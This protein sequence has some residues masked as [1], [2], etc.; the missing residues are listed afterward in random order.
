MKKLVSLLLIICFY[1]PLIAQEEEHRE[2]RERR[3]H[4]TSVHK[5]RGA[6]KDLTPDQIGTLKAKKMALE[7]DLNEKQKNELIKL[8][9]Q[10][11]EERK[12]KMEA[13]KAQR[14]KGENL[15]KEERFKFMN[16]RLDKALEVQQKMKKILNEEQYEQWKKRKE[17]KHRQRNRRKKQ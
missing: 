7:L 17:R 15:S 12:Q 4:K 2:Q 9:T 13:R 3:E 11:A 6:I 14:E 10:L 1:L 8:N 16:E 5:R